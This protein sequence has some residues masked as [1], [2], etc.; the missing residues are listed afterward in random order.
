[1]VKKSNLEASIIIRGKNE[2][3]W[4][5][6]LLPKLKKQSI[7]NFEIIFCDNGSK[8]NTLELLRKN[9]IKKIYK[10]KYYLPGKILNYAVKKA[11]GKYICI[12]SSHCI[13]VSN[14]WLEEHIFSIEK[15]KN[16]AAS[17]GRQIPLPGSSTQNLIDLDIIFKD[18]EITYKRDPYL[19]NA[20][21][22]Y[23]AQ[24][25]KKYNFDSKITNI[26]DRVWAN[27]IIRKGYEIFYSAK[28]EVFHL[29]GLHHHEH[30]SKRSTNTYNIMVKKYFKYWKN[31]KFLKKENLKF[32]LIIN[33]RREHDLVNLK[34]KL[35]F[36]LKKISPLKNI[37]SKIILISNSK[38][39]KNRK[40]KLV[41]GK[42]NLKK[43]LI[44]IYRNYKNSFVDI[45]YLIYLN[46]SKK[47]NINSLKKLIDDTIYFSRESACFG[48]NFNENFLIHYKNKETFK[49]T[50][51]IKSEDKP[52]V[53]IVELSMGAVADIDYLR[54]G[55]LITDNTFIE[56]D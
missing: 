4:L 39:I 46:L 1:M 15:N 16:Y 38:K 54:N 5:K 26:E 9:N 17:F 7:N 49:S 36:T 55:N 19:N 37:L 24:I 45:N 28:S 41:I 14:K 21:C 34:R 43:D 13:P 47:F 23:R 33:A 35:N 40:I 6:I 50:S 56:C 18:Q 42:N 29:H 20:N 22:I 31:C 44:D 32:C 8:D 53:T 27:K 10:F 3:K 12:L 48:K 52:K 25:L 11:S 2:A 30:K 51:L